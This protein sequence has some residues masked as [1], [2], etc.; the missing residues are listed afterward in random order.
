MTNSDLPSRALTIRLE[1]AI[2]EDHEVGD[3]M[4]GTEPVR[5]SVAGHHHSDGAVAGSIRLQLGAFITAGALVLRVAW[6]GAR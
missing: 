4:L 5:P 1:W 2:L 6:F 3:V